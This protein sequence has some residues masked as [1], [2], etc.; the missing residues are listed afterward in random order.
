MGELSNYRAKV[1]LLSGEK[2]S[3]RRRLSQ[4]V[5]AVIQYLK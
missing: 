1:D 2:A 5:V 4:R 3:G